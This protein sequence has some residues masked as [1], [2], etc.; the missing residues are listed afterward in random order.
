[1]KTDKETIILS[2]ILLVFALYVIY[3]QIRWEVTSKSY[4]IAYV[5]KSQAGVGAIT[6]GYYFYSINNKRYEG[7]VERGNVNLNKYF[8]VEIISSNPKL[9][10]IEIE[11]SIKPDLLIPQ[12]KEGWEECPIN[13]NGTIKEKFRVKNK[14]K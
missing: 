5:F 9:S 3:T 11:K 14:L 4:A 7:T 1:M 8:I 13:K 10:R 2:S 6:D 12:P